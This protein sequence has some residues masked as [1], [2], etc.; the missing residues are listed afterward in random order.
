M[1]P[2]NQNTEQPQNSN[3]PDRPISIN[4][5]VDLGS[6]NNSPNSQIRHAGGLVIQP[7]SSEDDIRNELN[8]T[9]TPQTDRANHERVATE[10]PSASR[11][12]SDAGIILDSDRSLS[13]EPKK[14]ALRRLCL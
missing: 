3:T 13:Q 5:P 6:I 9:P 7:I 12:L 2:N 11:R 14:M 10:S 1:Q 8:N 4:D